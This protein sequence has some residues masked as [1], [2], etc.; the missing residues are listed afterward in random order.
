MRIIV[1]EDHKIVL[2][3]LC[4]LLAGMKG[5]EVIAKHL[6]GQQVLA[7]LAI[8]PDIDLVISDVQMPVMG[9]IELTLKMRERFPNVKICLLTVADSPDAIRKAINAGA[10]GY[11]F[12]M[13]DVRELETAIDLISKG[14]K[15]YC[16]EA[17]AILARDPNTEFK[18]EV[19]K[20][21][22][23]AITKRELEVLKLIIQELSGTEIAE[24]LF[25][26]ATTV[27]THRKHLMQ[28][29]SAKSTVGLV[30]RALELRIV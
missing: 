9:G 12:K 5:I 16:A 2:D 20:L 17:L 22:N 7:T 23:L 14:S 10:D 4:G 19:E 8:D 18:P 3:S 24:K 21:G 13:V 27:E 29:L 1:A 11:V 15:Y 28:K 25:I 6:N 26:G 30:K